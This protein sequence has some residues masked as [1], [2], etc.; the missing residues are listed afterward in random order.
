MTR[1]PRNYHYEQVK[2]LYKTNLLYILNKY[3]KD[4][5]DLKMSRKVQIHGYNPHGEA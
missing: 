1:Y 3:L 5:R 4:R 2:D